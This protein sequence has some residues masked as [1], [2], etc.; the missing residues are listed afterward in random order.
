MMN[1][2]PVVSLKK[3]KELMTA[4]LRNLLQM[5]NNAKKTGQPI[6]YGDALPFGRGNMVK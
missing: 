4:P 1:F 2:Q 3:Q 6:Y 5:L